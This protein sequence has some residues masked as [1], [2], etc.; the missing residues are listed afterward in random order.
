[1]RR[2][3][4]KSWGAAKSAGDVGSLVWTLTRVVCGFGGKKDDRV[5]E[6]C[7]A[8][9]DVVGHTPETVNERAVFVFQQSGGLIVL[10]KILDVCGSCLAN[11]EV[12]L[13]LLLV[14]ATRTAH[15]DVHEYQYDNVARK[16][17]RLAHWSEWTWTPDEQPEVK[18]VAHC[19]LSSIAALCPAVREHHDVAAYLASMPAVCDT[20]TAAQAAA[21]S[22]PMLPE[23]TVPAASLAD[24][25]VPAA[26]LADP[27]VPA[28]TVPAPAVP[29]ATVPAPAVLAATVP[30]A[31]VSAPA[32]QAATVP[33]ATAPAP[34]VPA[35]T[36]P[37]ATVSAPAVPAATVPAATVPAATVSAPAVPA[38][39]VHPATEYADPLEPVLS[40]L[41]RVAE[42]CR[43]RSEAATAVYAALCKICTDDGEDALVEVELRDPDETRSG[44]WE[45][46]Y[47]WHPEELDHWAD[48][49]HIR[50]R[51][52]YARAINRCAVAF[53]PRA[54]DDIDWACQNM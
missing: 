21:A 29:A 10:G 15:G 25:A 39:T 42:T 19:V 53:C 37:A 14:T 46:W 4:L 36:V 28:A 34:A 1:M 20:L 5:V 12:A 51:W 48:S 24:P 43:T 31:T 18:R 41:S 9:L 47:E 27:A 17:M 26:S 45:V 30:A 11:I 33:A 3:V 23:P 7:N 2:S 38:A 16:V 49:V 50:G 44:W 32:V 22:A 40:A 8:I 52:G 13:R 35:A 54:A 6:M